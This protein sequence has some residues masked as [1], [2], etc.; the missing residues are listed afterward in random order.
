M[1]FVRSFWPDR[2]EDI[3]PSSKTKLAAPLDAK[4]R[5]M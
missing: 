2:L 1:F 3:R 5:K 4:Q